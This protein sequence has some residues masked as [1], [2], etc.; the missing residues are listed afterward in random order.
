[1]SGKVFSGENATQGTEEGSQHGIVE[2]LRSRPMLRLPIGSADEELDGQ[3][4]AIGVC[5]HK[6]NDCT[7]EAGRIQ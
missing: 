5:R 4:P 7:P 2:D 3:H 1:M 6:T